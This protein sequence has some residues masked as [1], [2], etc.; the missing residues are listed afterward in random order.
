MQRL[1]DALLPVPGV[2]GFDLGLQG[3]QVEPVRAGEVQVADGDDFAQ[4][5]AGGGEHVRIHVQRGFLRHVGHAQVLLQL[6][7]AVVWLFQPAQYLEH[8][9]LAGAVAADQAD[10]FRFEKREV[11]MI[12]Q[13]DVTERELR[14]EECDECHV[15]R[16]IGGAG[17]GAWRLGKKASLWL[18]I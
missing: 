18:S 6:Q 13:R 3:V 15:A 12:Q 11:R 14:V 16:I 17:D 9:R 4:A 5:L 2:V 8:R 7:R 1:F 10:A